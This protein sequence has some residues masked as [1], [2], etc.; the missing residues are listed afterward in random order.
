MKKLRLAVVNKLS[1]TQVGT[2]QILVTIIIISKFTS[3]LCVYIFK[4]FT[5]YNFV[6]TTSLVIIVNNF[7][8]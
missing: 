8:I 7:L 5:H 6:T 3:S 1:N 2:T 4:V